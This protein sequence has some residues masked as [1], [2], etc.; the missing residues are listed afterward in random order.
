[1]SDSLQPHELQSM[2]LSWQEYR[3]GLPFPT[4][5]DLPYPGI[6]PTSPAAPTLTGGA[7]TTESFTWEAPGESVR[8]N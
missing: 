3:G 1:M 2:G 8:D 5:E 7:F 6:E 4:P